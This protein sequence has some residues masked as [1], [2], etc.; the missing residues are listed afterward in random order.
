MI[1][2]SWRLIALYPHLL[3][4]CVALGGIIVSDAKFILNK[5]QLKENDRILLLELSKIVSAALLLLWISGLSIIL[6]DFASWPSLAELAAKPKL[7]AK[8]T[9]VTI[10]T[11]NGYLLHRM[12]LPTFTQKTKLK[13]ISTPRLRSMFA[14]G[15]ISGTSWLFAAFLGIAKPL[16][17]TLGLSGFLSLYAV[18]LLGAVSTAMLLAPMVKTKSNN[19]NT[20]MTA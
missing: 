10:L 17:T 20:L 13:T 9:V 11:I 7:I 18:L 16:S 5:G 15:A 6:I 2:S 3:A 14:L 4:C 12:V 1:E 19:P 8:L